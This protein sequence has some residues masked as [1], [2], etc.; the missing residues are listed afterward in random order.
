ME[1]V[2]KDILEL[3][4]NINK[5]FEINKINKDSDRVLKGKDDVKLKFYCYRCGGSIYEL[6]ECYFRNEICRKCGK[7]GYI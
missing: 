3:Q 1:A 6:V 7:L 4:G 2:A 5:E